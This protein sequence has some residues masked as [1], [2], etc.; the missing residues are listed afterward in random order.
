M[1]RDEW[2][3]VA[4]NAPAIALYERLGLVEGARNRFWVKP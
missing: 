4:S 3:G 2:N 1:T